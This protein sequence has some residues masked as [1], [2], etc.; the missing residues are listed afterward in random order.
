MKDSSKGLLLL[1][2]VGAGNGSEKQS[3]SSLETYT[4]QSK[5]G[6]V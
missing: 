5:S 4:C 1:R 2:T 3:M 6:R